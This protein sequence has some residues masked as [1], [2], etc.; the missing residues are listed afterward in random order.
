MTRDDRRRVAL[1]LKTA[2]TDGAAVMAVREFIRVEEARSRRDA[3]VRI[4][5][6]QLALI[7]DVLVECIP[8]KG[9]IPLIRCLARQGARTPSGHG[10]GYPVHEACAHCPLREVHRTLAGRFTPARYKAFNI[11][12]E[13]KQ[14]AA[15]QVLIRSGA[16]DP[17]PTLD[18][19]IAD[20]LG[21]R[22]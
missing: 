4:D 16:L 17:V 5:P 21:G 12:R 1:L 7:D 8:D 19:P 11:A 10:K 22:G 2:K 6:R 3:A 15:R 20:E 14:R 13:A 9:R 18:D